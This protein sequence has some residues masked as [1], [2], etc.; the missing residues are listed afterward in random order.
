MTRAVGGVKEEAI[1]VPKSKPCVIQVLGAKPKSFD[2][3]AMTWVTWLILQ[4]RG[5]WQGQEQ[6]QGRQRGMRITGLGLNLE[7]WD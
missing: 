1:G 7:T 5:Q 6:G 4:E 2:W 3:L